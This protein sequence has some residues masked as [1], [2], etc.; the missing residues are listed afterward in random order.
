MKLTD[1]R[2][3]AFTTIYSRFFN[4]SE[5]DV[6]ANGK[7][8]GSPGL[9]VQGDASMIDDKEYQEFITNIIK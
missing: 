2:E 8:L 3:L 9:I 1:A 6:F 5:E 7:T 4:P